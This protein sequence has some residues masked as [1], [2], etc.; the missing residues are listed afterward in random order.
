MSPLGGQI[1]MKVRGARHPSER[2]HADEYLG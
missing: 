2:Q 1:T